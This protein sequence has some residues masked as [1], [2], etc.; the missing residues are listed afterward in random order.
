MRILIRAY[1]KFFFFKYGGFVHNFVILRASNKEA[2]LQFNEYLKKCREGCKLTQEK[3]AQDLYVHD[4]ELFEGLDTGTIGKWERGLTKPKASKQASILKYFQL[5]TNSALPFLDEYQL[6]ELEGLLCKIGMKNML[7]K[8]K[9]HV[10]DFPSD[11]MSMDD[12]NVTALHNFDGMEQVIENNMF[13]H[14]D[15]THPYSQLSRKQFLEWALHPSNLFLFCE[16]KGSSLG[17]MFLVR[18]KPD[19][20]K[21]IINFEMKKSDLTTDDFASYDEMGS[22]MI[23]SFFALNSKAATLLYIRYYAHLI[24]NQ[25]NIAEVGGISHTD[26][27][28]NIASKMNLKFHK[29]FIAEDGI[30]IM[31]F[32]QTLANVLSSEYVVKMLL[33]KQACPEE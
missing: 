13:L 22:H 29:S 27:G 23:L 26:E 12:I 2:D 18:V 10:Y 21:K 17:L 11:M 24:A 4:T 3:L 20:Y 9:K 32:S 33:S 7:G 8:N 16:H 25:D 31:S 30:K 1:L 6:E 14:K 28:R 5:Q 19:I 15:V